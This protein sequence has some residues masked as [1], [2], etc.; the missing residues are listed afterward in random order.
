MKKDV[1]RMTLALGILLIL[2]MALMFLVPFEKGGNFAIVVAFTVLSFVV[3]GW[4]IYTAFIRKP[5]AKS[6]FYGF[7]IAK[8]GVIYCVIQI[9]ASIVL[10]VIGQK[11]LWWFDFLVCLFLLG[12]T[13]IG[14]ISVEAVV[15]EI[16]I[17]EV[18][19]HKDVAT[20]REL[21]SRI[22]LLAAQS[23]RLKAN[24]DVKKL[25]EEIKYSDPVSNEVTKE[26]EMQ[27]M[28]NLEEMKKAI[29]VSDEDQVEKLC[30]TSLILLEERN[31]LC[32]MNK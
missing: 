6:R 4:S 28:N 31:K 5:D 26:L 7:S 9:I 10:A 2:Y 21:Q 11:L 23:E 12:I 18:K 20:M 8:L 24:I 22:R 16:K 15:E 32:K 3:A 19:V 25:A 29:L 27:L 14:L 13:L 17:Q 1:K 30:K